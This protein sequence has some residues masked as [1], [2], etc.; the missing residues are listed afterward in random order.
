MS[1]RD[2]SERRICVPPGATRQT[3]AVRFVFTNGRLETG[4]VTGSNDP[5]G[6][7]GSLVERTGPMN[8]RLSTRCALAGAI[9]VLGA[10]GSS[11]S[12]STG[13]GGDTATGGS[14]GTGG[15]GTETGG[16]PPVSATAAA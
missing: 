2:L 15:A 8:C 12:G 5:S 13:S 7:P 3:N 6:S 11:T 16:S 9:L 1:L 4:R 14:L 10:C